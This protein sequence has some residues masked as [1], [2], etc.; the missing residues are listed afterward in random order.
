VALA[1]LTTGAAVGVGAGVEAVPAE[2][3]ELPQ[4]TT[5][6]AATARHTANGER[7]IT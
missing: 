5:S 1:V 2:L 4:A 3:D 7:L 6:S